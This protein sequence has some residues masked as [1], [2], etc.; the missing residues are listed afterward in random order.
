MTARTHDAFAFAGLITVAVFYPPTTLNL[1]TLFA[2]IVGNIVGSLIPDMDQA[3][4]RLW[5]LLPAGDHLA[6]VFR[7]LFLKHRTL[8]HSFLGVFLIFNILGFVLPR[9][10]NPNFVNVEI[11]FAAVMIGYVSHLV[12]DSL[13]KDGLPLLFP[14][15]YN[16]GFPPIKALRIVTGSWIENWLILPGVGAYIFWFLGRNQEQLLKILNLL[17]N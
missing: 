5:D 2:A 16:F 17:S 7:R 13:T 6:K 10:L 15:K 1:T 12:A 4:N 8:T 9:L 11:V 3:S 14:I